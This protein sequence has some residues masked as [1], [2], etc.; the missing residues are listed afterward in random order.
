[1]LICVIYKRAGVNRAKHVIP[2]KFECR[3]KCADFFL[4]SVILS[5]CKQI[6]PTNKSV[7][8]IEYSLLLKLTSGV[9][10]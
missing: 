1:M 8:S 10:Q 9:V 5:Y 3:W 7:I 2:L 4:T 6:R